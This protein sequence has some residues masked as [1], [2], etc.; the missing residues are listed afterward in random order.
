[1]NLGKRI[2]QKLKELGWERKDL[3]DKVPELSTSNLS[4]LI[5][6]DSKRSE[7]DEKIAEALGVS[8]LWL[9]YGRYPEQQNRFGEIVATESKNVTSLTHPQHP[10]VAEVVTLMNNTDELGKG[11]M[12]AKARDIAKERPLQTNKPS[13]SI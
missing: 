4:A 12:L 5:K 11:M 9:V 7:L 8:L 2:E 13:S 6:R 1:M 3:M 10:A